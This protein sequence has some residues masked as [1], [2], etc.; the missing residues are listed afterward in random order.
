[1]F[2]C[3]WHTPQS[4][5]PVSAQSDLKASCTFTLALVNPSFLSRE[6]VKSQKNAFHLVIEEDLFILFYLFIT[7]NVVYGI[8]KGDF[9]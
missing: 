8:N 1:M 2:D 7:I 9:Q 5:S 3:A 4:L 6:H